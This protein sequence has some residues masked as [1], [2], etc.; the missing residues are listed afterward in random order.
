M[1]YIWDATDVRERLGCVVTNDA[2]GEHWVLS[3][4]ACQRDEQRYCLVSL[5]D[6]MVNTRYDAETMAQILTE[7]NRRPLLKRVL[8]EEL[9]KEGLTR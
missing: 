9:V 3:Y 5:R 7:E 4:D 1:K 2:K 8:T 6:G